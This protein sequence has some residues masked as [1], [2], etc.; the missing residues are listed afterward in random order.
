MLKND[1]DRANLVL[2]TLGEQPIGEDSQFSNADQD[3]VVDMLDISEVIF[4]SKDPAE[5][6]EARQTLG[7]MESS[8]SLAVLD[9]FKHSKLKELR[10]NVAKLNVVGKRL[11]QLEDRLPS[12][13]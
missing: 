12:K 9:Q 13:E 6:E 2:E 4:E 10:T 11:A 5:L 8:L 3:F 1:F 7:D